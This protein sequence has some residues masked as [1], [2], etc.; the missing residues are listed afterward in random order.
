MPLILASAIHYKTCDKTK[1][2]Q[3]NVDANKLYYFLMN[4]NVKKDK[5]RKII[6]SMLK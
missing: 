3:S 2:T 4:V 1:C 6:K 5:S